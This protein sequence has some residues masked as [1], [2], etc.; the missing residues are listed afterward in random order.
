MHL[1]VTES[2]HIE[3]RDIP[4]IVLY[5]VHVPAEVISHNS[6]EIL[7]VDA[8]PWMTNNIKLSINSN[9]I[10]F[11]QLPIYLVPFIN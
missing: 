10:K 7:F 9:L 4:I 5:S 8:W 3:A 1:T 6:P 2:T 11:T